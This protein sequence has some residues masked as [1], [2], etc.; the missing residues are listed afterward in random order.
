MA[1]ALRDPAA[2]EMLEAETPII[3]SPAALEAGGEG[4]EAAIG[5]PVD[6]LARR[7]HPRALYA[8]GAGEAVPLSARLSGQTIRC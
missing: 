4:E 8:L 2:L 6:D 5:E 7:G 3:Q 1:G